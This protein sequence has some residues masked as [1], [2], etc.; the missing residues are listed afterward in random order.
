M[1][2]A[3]HARTLYRPEYAARTGT[4]ENLYDNYVW[5]AI[6]YSHFAIA[7]P[8]LTAQIDLDVYMY[9]Y[10]IHERET[11]RSGHYIAFR[12]RQKQ[13]K[14]NGTTKTKRV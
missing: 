13:K 5:N 2:E 4:N 11:I 10:Y 8:N 3:I 14:K 12:T 9:I 1:N 6:C 7:K